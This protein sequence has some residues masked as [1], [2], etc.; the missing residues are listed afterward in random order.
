MRLRGFGQNFQILGTAGRPAISSAIRL[1]SAPRRF[2]FA[3]EWRH[4]TGMPSYRHSIMP[5]RKT[6][7][8]YVPFPLLGPVLINQLA[9]KLT[10]LESQSDEHTVVIQRQHQRDPI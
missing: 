8:L 2:S 6:Y 1:P 10:D 7:K 4:Q 3:R 9:E 5:R